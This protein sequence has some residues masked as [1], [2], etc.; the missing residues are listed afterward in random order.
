MSKPIAV[1][2]AAACFGLALWPAGAVAAQD[3]QGL[4]LTQSRAMDANKDGKISEAEFFAQ[5]D[6]AALWQEL[7]ANADGV[8]DAEEQKQAVQVRPLTVN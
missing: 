2:L 5:S 8:L 3:P 4:T 6:D 1:L 7:D